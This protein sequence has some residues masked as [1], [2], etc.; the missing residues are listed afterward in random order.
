M[1]KTIAPHSE[2]AAILLGNRLTPNAV[3]SVFIFSILFSLHF[4]TC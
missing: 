4:L 2:I 1:R 3:T